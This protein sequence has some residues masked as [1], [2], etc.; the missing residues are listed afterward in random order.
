M[1]GFRRSVPSLYNDLKALYAS[2]GK[3]E[4][5]DALVAGYR[6]E[7]SE[8][9]RFMSGDEKMSA[10]PMCAVWCDYFWC[11]RLVEARRYDEALAVINSALERVPTCIELFVLKAKLYKHVGNARLAFE[12]L[13]Y[14]RELDTADRYLNTKCVRY[15]LRALDVERARE[16]VVM[17]LKKKEGTQSLHKLQV[18]W[19]QMHLAEAHIARHEYGP[20]LKQLTN[21][22][23]HFDTFWKNQTDFHRY[24]YR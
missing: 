24:T 7:L 11:S 14:A 1:N 18:M 16:I 8:N 10:S 3:G 4:I 6:K 17:F 21:V 13:D 15:A 23:Y 5:V 9:Y 22:L 19:F 20:A 2:A 12:C